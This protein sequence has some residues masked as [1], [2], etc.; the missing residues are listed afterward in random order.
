MKTTLVRVIC[1][2]RKDRDSSPYRI[3][4]KK[5]IDFVEQESNYIG[6]GIT[7]EKSRLGKIETHYPD[8]KNDFVEYFTWCLNT[9]DD[10][11]ASIAS[12]KSAVDTTLRQLIA[13]GVID[14][15]DFSEEPIVSV[16]MNKETGK[17]KPFKEIA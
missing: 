14:N 15:I 2:Y 13:L 16:Q 4:I 7:I 8:P 11:D 5:N 12:V 17:E 9:D 6:Y 10:L 1:S 3:T